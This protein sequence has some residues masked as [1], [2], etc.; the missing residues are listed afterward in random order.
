M[1]PRPAAQ[2]TSPA[3][4]RRVTPPPAPQSPTHL[5]YFILKNNPL[6]P[7]FV[8]SSLVLP[9]VV[10]LETHVVSEYINPIS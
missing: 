2:V 9:E 4:P 10:C 6:A 8:F 1:L 3:Y 5:Y 7:I